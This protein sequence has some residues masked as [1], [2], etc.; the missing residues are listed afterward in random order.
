MGLLGYN[1]VGCFQFH[2]RG[3][4]YKM[5][6][7]TC[8]PVVDWHGKVV[9]G[10]SDERGHELVQNVKDQVCLEDHG[11]VGN[12]SEQDLDVEMEEV[13]LMDTL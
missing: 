1:R 13:R 3:L 4:E 6:R 10:V 5:V 12:G 11:V 7:P 2:R 9:D 8:V